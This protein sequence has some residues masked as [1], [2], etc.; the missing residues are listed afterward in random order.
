MKVYRGRRL[1]PD[2][3]TASLVEVLVEE[4][5]LAQP[6]RH[7]VYHSPTGFSWGFWGSGPA[8]LARSILWD[9]L[10]EYRAKS[11]YQQFKVQFVGKWG[12]EWEISEE[13]IQEWAVRM[14]VAIG[15]SVQS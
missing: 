3:Q 14:A 6:L 2:R 11:L 7:R 10:D 15:I 9:C 4:N 13:E 8:D 12:Q 5:G 1:E